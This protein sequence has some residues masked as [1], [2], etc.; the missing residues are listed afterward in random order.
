MSTLKTVGGPVAH[1]RFGCRT[2]R[3]YHDM[4]IRADDGARLVREVSSWE[5]KHAGHQ[6]ELP[7]IL[8]V[9]VP[10]DQPALGEPEVEAAPPWWHPD[11]GYRENTSFQT[12]YVASSALTITS[13]NSL[14]SDGSLLA[15]ASSAVVDNGATGG[16]L[17]LLITAQI[18]NGTTPTTAKE[19]DLYAWAKLDDSTYP[20]NITGSDATVSA[21]SSEVTS[22]GVFKPLVSWPSSTT[23]GSTYPTGWHTLGGVELGAAYGGFLPR[24][25]GVWIVHNTVAAFA[26]S[27][28]V[29]TEKGLYVAA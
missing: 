11:A 23:T 3:K 18:K 16:P 13:F 20:D 14:A 5:Y 22:A 29:V 12:S 1:V 7:V 25:W 4:P 10:R 26:A 17:A 21:S 19:V 8:R 27:G 28:H 15:G 9:D 24:Y 6:L 2:C